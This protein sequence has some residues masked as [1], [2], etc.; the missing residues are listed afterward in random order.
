MRKLFTA[1]LCAAAF[2]TANAAHAAV[3]NFNDPGEIVIDND[4]FIATY[5]ESGFAISGAAATFLPLDSALVGGIDGSTPFSLKDAGGGSFSLLSLD[6][7]FYDLG[8][9]AAAG[10]LSVTGLLNGLQVAS[11]MFSLGAGAMGS[12]GAAFGNVT[13]VTF[14]GTSG[15]S[16]DNVNVTPVPE[17]ETVAL[18]A[19]GLLALGWRVRRRVR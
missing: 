9:G 2:C 10:M 17:P 13:E 6:Y 12:F 11:Q 14:S 5:T 8:F 3:L 1:L 18:M 4:T 19:L 16:I 15:F 7:G